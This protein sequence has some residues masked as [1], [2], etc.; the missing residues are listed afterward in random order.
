MNIQHLLNAVE[1]PPSRSGSSYGKDMARYPSYPQQQHP[2]HY[3]H[4]QRQQQ[5]PFYA[6]PPSSYQPSGY[7]DPRRPVLPSYHHE[8]P[9]LT[10][11]QPYNH[12][13]PQAP[14]SAHYSS[15]P[16]EYSPQQPMRMFFSAFFTLVPL[17]I[18]IRLVHAQLYR[19]RLTAVSEFQ[20]TL[21][22]KCLSPL[23]I[24][25]QDRASVRLQSR[26]PPNYVQPPEDDYEYNSPPSSLSRKRSRSATDSAPKAK[27][28]RKTPSS[29]PSTSGE[30]PN[31]MFAF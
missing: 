30:F 9:A 4:E 3:A 11:H 10:A 21:S 19:R 15:Y 5:Q 12:H 25:Q 1:Q 6:S 16:G 29:I 2:I 28:P 23:D 20:P 31:H 24:Q 13:H 14:S 26:P 22:T 17:F 7:S 18:I 8:Q 27:K